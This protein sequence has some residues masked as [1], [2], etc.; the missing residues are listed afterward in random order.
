MHRTSALRFKQNHEA[1]QRNRNISKRVICTNSQAARNTPI[2]SL[3]SSYTHFTSR[4][5][6]QGTPSSHQQVTYLVQQQFYNFT[7]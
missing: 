4:Y 3:L 1:V 7:E 2:R 5:L 6:S